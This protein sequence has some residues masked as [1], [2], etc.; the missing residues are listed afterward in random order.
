MNLERARR[1]FL[2]RLAQMKHEAGELGMWK[3]VQALDNTTRVA[4][5]ELA[6]LLTGAQADTAR[7]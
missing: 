2:I 7:S 5:F 4:G 3:T 1:E 6:D